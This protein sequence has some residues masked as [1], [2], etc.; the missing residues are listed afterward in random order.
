VLKQCNE[1][2]VVFRKEGHMLICTTRLILVSSTVALAATIAHGQTLV[3]GDAARELVQ[4]LDAIGVTAIA[5][6]DPNQ[7]GVFVA[8]LYVP[9]SQLLV[10]RARHPSVDAL[11]YRIDAKQFRDVYL[12]LQAT[13]TPQGKFFVQDSKADGVLDTRLGSGDID[14]LY[15]DGVRQTLFN[16]DRRAQQLSEAEYKAKLSAADTEYA[17]LLGLLTGA[18]RASLESSRTVGTPRPWERLPDH[19]GTKARL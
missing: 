8:A 3:S 4:R 1:R 13:P 19:A 17:R 16:G 6:K 10:V 14:V 11:T 18:V 9:A 15:E 7:S 5:A 12:D 2:N